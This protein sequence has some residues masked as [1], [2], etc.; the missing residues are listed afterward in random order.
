MD[1]LWLGPYTIHR[2]LGKGLYELKNKEGKLVKKKANINCLKVYTRR[3]EVPPSSP[4]KSPQSSPTKSPSQK[5]RVYV[6]C[7]NTITIIM[8]SV[9]GIS[10]YVLDNYFFYAQHHQ[11]YVERMWKKNLGLTVRDKVSLTK[12]GKLCDRHMNAANELLGCPVPSPSRSPI[13]PPISDFIYFNSGVWWLH[14]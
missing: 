11:T 9:W 8:Y 7:V 2:N 12:K 10:I 1:P 5:R 13:N 14:V 6:L 4:N 3:N